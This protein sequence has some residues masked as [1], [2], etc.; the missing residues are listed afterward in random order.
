MNTDLKKFIAN[1]VALSEEELEEIAGKFRYK[2][3]AKNDHLLKQ[4]NTCKDIVFVQ[5][6][7][8]RLFYIKDDIEIS[9]WFAF[10]GS[11]AIEIN[12]F[13]S[14]KP[15]NYFLQAIEDSEVLYLP[16]TELNALYKQQPKMQEMMRNFWE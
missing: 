9:V 13:I 11:S 1:Y 12:S 3:T 15:S 16:K 7:C 2:A 6:G 14:G 8:L 4:G 5:N 10:A